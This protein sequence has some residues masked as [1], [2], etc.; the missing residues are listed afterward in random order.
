MFL[1]FNHFNLK[2]FVCADDDGEIRIEFG[3]GAPDLVMTPAEA[4]ALRDKIT[5]ALAASQ[6]KVAA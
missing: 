5:S 4:Q 6:E 2:P 3:N 1:S